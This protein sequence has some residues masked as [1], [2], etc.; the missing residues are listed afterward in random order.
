MLAV[1]RRDKSF[2]GTGAEFE[3]KERDAL[4]LVASRRDIDRALRYLTMGETEKLSC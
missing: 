3:V 4:I 1:V 2:V